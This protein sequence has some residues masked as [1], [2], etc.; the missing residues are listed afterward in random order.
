M[1][2]CATLRSWRSP[3]PR[4]RPSTLERTGRGGRDALDRQWAAALRRACD[5]AGANLRGVYVSTS[6]GVHPVPPP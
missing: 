1:P 4:T 5:R 6:G 3:T 2:C